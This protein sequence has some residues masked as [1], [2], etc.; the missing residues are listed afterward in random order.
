MARPSDPRPQRSPDGEDALAARPVLPRPEA[1]EPIVPGDGPAG[2][3]EA[4]LVRSLRAGD[5][6]A[7]ERVVRELGGRLYATAL[8]MLGNEDDARD[9]VQD[10][11]LSAFKSIARFDEQSTLSTWLHR[12]VINSSLMK[13]RTRRRKPA[14]SIDAM[15]P[16]LREGEQ[17][18]SAAG[19]AP[20]SL[21]PWLS[22]AG[23]DAIDQA[24]LRT[25]LRDEIQQ[26]PD[27]YRTVVMLRDIEELD[28][29]ETAAVL[30]ISESAVKTRLHR[31]RQLLRERLDAFVHAR[32]DA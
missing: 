15:L 14:V 23:A 2:Y 6:A 17:A 7:Y 22:P 3:G 25:R 10:A 9:A 8:R 21:R 18:P 19:N 24:E 30:D 5:A 4:A 13:L 27:D 31:A 11:F 26:L 12:I 32:T 28:T 29:A 1:I 20:G 16:A